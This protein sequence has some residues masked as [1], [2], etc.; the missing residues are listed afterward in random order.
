MLRSLAAL[1]LYVCLAVPAA[2][3][4]QD[5]RVILRAMALTN[6]HDA[7]CTATEKCA[8]A[9]PAEMAKPTVPLNAVGVAMRAGIRSAVVEKCGGKYFEQSFPPFTRL[10]RDS[11]MFQEREIA[12]LTMIHGITLGLMRKNAACNDRWRAKA[13]L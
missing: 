12:Q 6:L 8:P 9:I 3:E 10:I 5:P 4:E 1:T 11:K 13:G 7:Q 2:A